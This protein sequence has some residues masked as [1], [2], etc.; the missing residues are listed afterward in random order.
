MREVF[1]GR[2]LEV[3]FNERFRTSNAKI[4]C[5]VVN[6]RR[7]KKKYDD[8][9]IDKQVYISAGFSSAVFVGKFYRSTGNDN[10]FFQGIF[11]IFCFNSILQR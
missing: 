6:L 2:H 9:Y 5:I 8:D 10:L 1:H 11:Q 7:I 4:A 3:E